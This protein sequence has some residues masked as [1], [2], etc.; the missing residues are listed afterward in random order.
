MTSY[1]I[2]LKARIENKAGHLLTL[3]IFLYTGY[4]VFL[5]FKKYYNFVYNIGDLA[6][7]N[8]V[9]FNTLHGRWFDLSINLNNYL[10][11]HFS[12]II[13]LLLPFY[14]LY[15]EAPSLLVMQVLFFTLSA[16]PIFLLAKKITQDK[17]QSLF[18]AWL[19]L[20]NPYLQIAITY[21]FH[22]YGLAFFLILWCFYFYYNNRFKLFLLFFILALTT[23]E[24]IVFVLLAFG[25]LAYLD[26]KTSKWWLSSLLLAGS[27]FLLA[28]L[29]I[30]HFAIGNN[31]EY[32]AYYAWLGGDSFTS[33]VLNWLKHPLQVFGHIF[34]V[35]NLSGLF[36]TLLVF[37]F[38]P[39]VKARYLL[40]SLL[41]FLIF[42]LTN[43]GFKGVYQ[44]Y[45]VSILLPGIYISFIFAWQ[46]LKIK[47]KFIFSNIIYKYSRY[48]KISFITNVILFSFLLSPVFVNLIKDFSQNQRQA[49]NSILANI[50]ANASIAASS[51]LLPYLS[52]RSSAY[53]L[54]YAY[55]ESTQFASA[56]FVLP[57]VDYIVVNQS[58]F[59]I[60]LSFAQ[61]SIF[62]KNKK[63]QAPSNWRKLLMDYK[64]V[65]VDNNLFLWEN[66][67][68]SDLAALPFYEINDKEEFFTEDGFLVNSS[69][70]R[71]KDQSVLKLTF[72]NKDI[73]SSNYLIRFYQGQ[74]YFDMPLDYGLLSNQDWQQDKL[75][76]FYYYLDETID[77]Y[78][79]FNWTGKARLGYLQE[80]ILEFKEL[81]KISEKININ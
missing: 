52:S 56:K 18:L 68:K 12:P 31:Y 48:F 25:P 69:L 17:I 38:I 79:I 5:V 23:R 66:K 13:F 32:L 42:T 49:K 30:K 39:L 81:K 37:L 8:Q 55:L 44:S 61:D 2:K 24:D 74:D 1:L 76:S 21:E 10:G 34:Q 9:F 59:L 15:Q 47:E 22:L 41:P 57:A 40:L 70:N 4:F 6:I 77:G 43:V 75:F 63:E 62:Y 7:Y 26:H 3:L 46:R 60:T 36:S 29:S 65:R 80:R 58:D 53:W 73:V 67:N 33:I 50:P 64:L 11:F 19:W 35:D 16:W 72:Q 71:L 54:Q 14:Y 28:M 20:I 78:Q 45:Y 27:Y 51:D